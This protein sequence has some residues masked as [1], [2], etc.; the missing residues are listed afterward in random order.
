MSRRRHIRIQDEL[1]KHA[2]VFLERESSRASL[3]TV[4]GAQ[5]SPNL[6]EATIFISVFPTER[7]EQAIDFIKRQERDFRLYLSEHARLQ[8][9]P[10]IRFELDRGEKNRRRIDELL[11]Q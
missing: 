4:T 9:M 6:R 2:A 1:R 8:R 5:M 10:R 11:Q 7:E 3:I